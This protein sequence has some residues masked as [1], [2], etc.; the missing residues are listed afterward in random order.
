MEK[1]PDSDAIIGAAIELHRGVGLGLGGT[2]LQQKRLV[3]GPSENLRQSA[4]SVDESF[5]K[6]L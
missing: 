1:D 4:K 3:L 2:S 6:N 5:C